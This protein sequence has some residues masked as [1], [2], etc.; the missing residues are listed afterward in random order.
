MEC[1]SAFSFVSV[2][3]RELTSTFRSGI[4]FSGA[5]LEVK[6]CKSGAN[7]DRYDIIATVGRASIL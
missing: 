6:V 7:T 1:P 5:P 4:N 3:E 2:Q